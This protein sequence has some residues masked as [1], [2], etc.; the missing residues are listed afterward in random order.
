M[1]RTFFVKAVLDE[2]AHVFYAQSDIEGLHIEASSLDEFEAIIIE[3][4]PELI[5]ANHRISS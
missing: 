1:K 5:M 4:A 2:E 3:E